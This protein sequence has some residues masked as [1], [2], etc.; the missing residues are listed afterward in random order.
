MPGEDATVTAYFIPEVADVSDLT[1]IYDG[2]EH[3]IEVTPPAGFT[4][5]WYDAAE[6]G[7]EIPAPSGTNAGEYTGWAVLVDINDIESER[8][9]ATLT[10]TLREV[11][12]IANNLTKVYGDADPSLTFELA[13]EDLLMP[14]D[15]VSG[16]LTREPGEDVGVYAINQGT[17]AIS[18]NY[19]ITFVPGELE[20]EQLTLIINVQPKTK[21]YGDAD[22]ELTYILIDNEL[23]FDDTFTGALTREPGEDVGVYN[24]LIGTLTAGDNYAYVFEGDEL[25]ITV[26]PVTLAAENMGKVYGEA[27][28]L[29]TVSLAQGLLI[30][31]D[32]IT[33]APEREA[34]E[35]IGEYDILQGTIAI[36]DNYTITF[37]P[38]VF[39]ITTKELTIGGT[40]AVADK[41]F[42]GT[43]DA[44]ITTN[45]LTLVG[46]VGTDDVT[47]INLVAEFANAGPATNIEVTLTAAELDGTTKDNYTLTLAGAPV[48]TASIGNVLYTLTVNVTPAA[49]GTVTGAGNYA[50]GATVSLEATPAE[51]FMFVRWEDGLGA[52]LGTSTSLSYTMPAADATL[53]AVFQSTI[54]VEE[55]V[56][57]SVELFPNPARERVTIRT[58]GM[59]EQ[60]FIT[61]ITGRMVYSADVNESELTLNTGNFNTGIYL[62]RIH[63]AEGVVVKKMEVK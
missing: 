52:T 54:N 45:N 9:Q 56:V 61:D 27:D 33:G 63:T 3:S 18:T 22:P 11:T 7:S 8:V 2:T 58:E 13:P 20:I 40:F 10:I 23:Q 30:S 24:I 29:L 50:E 42:D 35:N 36:S 44:T 48:T 28:P 5:K 19:N 14:G 62:V 39:T 16:E 43:T 51:N 6:G 21:M 41:V 1:V 59:I 60:V 17:L 12:L 15:F 57:G 25:E 49:S 47:L 38:G 4:A 53:T 46:V 37:E 34:G 55:L 26:R 32:A 31:G